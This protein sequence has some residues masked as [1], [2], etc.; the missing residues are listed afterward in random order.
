[1]TSKT[2]RLTNFGT[3][4]AICIIYATNTGDIFVRQLMHIYRRNLNFKLLLL[5]MRVLKVNIC[6]G[7][8]HA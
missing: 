4:I 5:C 1:M 8:P 6:E 7:Y 3:D 2:K